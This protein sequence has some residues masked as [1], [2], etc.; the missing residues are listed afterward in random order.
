MK[1]SSIESPHAN[2][3]QYSRLNAMIVDDVK[4][5]AKTLALILS[6]LG[7]KVTTAFDGLSAMQKIDDG[8][9]DIVFLDIAMPGMDGL[10][11]A[12]RVRS[13]P[14]LSGVFL[15]ALTGF[16][17][18]GDRQRSREAGFNEHLIKPVSMSSLCEVLE[19]AVKAK[20]QQLV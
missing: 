2:A 4:A 12:K 18:E 14:N 8:S 11:V 7:P 6:S 3:D 20:Q 17:Q 16:G 9:F 15:V 1:S 13:N 10:E 5:S 19:R